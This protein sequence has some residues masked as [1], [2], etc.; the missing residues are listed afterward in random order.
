[1]KKVV[2][3][4]LNILDVDYYAPDSISSRIFA[5]LSTK[6]FDHNYRID[7]SPYALNLSNNGIRCEVEEIID[8]GYEKFAKLN[9]NGR[10]IYLNVNDDIDGTVFINIDFNNV[11]ITETSIDMKLI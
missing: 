10:I 4:K 3:F 8:Y 2:N 1:M 7:F 6:A 5:A 9:A 11:G